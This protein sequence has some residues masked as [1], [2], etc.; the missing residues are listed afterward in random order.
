MRFDWTKE[1]IE[2]IADNFL[3]MS[4]SDMALALGC[5][6]C[7]VARY[8]KKNGLSVPKE[9]RYAIQSA[10]RVGKTSLT[11]EQQKFIRDNYL[12]MPVNAMATKIGRFETPVIIFMRN[13][14]LVV[15][16][17]TIAQRKIDSRIKPGQPSHNKGRKQTDYMTPDQIA[18]TARTRFKKGNVPPNTK[19]EGDGTITI[20]HEHLNRGG[21]RP[22]KY[23]RI[24]LGK[25][26]PLHVHLWEEING[27]L[28]K[29]H[30]LW[31]LDED[32]LNADPA[33][34][35]LITRAESM[36]RNSVA[37]LS[38]NSVA[39]YLAVKSKKIDKDLKAEFLKH[40][41]LIN[42]KRAQLL[43]NR[44]INNN[45]KSQN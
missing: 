12:T 15:P 33:N 44:Q 43:L 8:L 31:C 35:E 39:N 4:G 16:P 38:D 20:R 45:G 14:N 34:Y 23:I 37:N 17:E 22:V 18:K 24:S 42:L 19:A 9:V 25:W 7:V 30:C 41:E 6:K 27:T 28:P 21:G 40:P 10:K 32:T 11:D 36:R 5:G 29:S 1:R 3:S 2:F 26:K 13:N